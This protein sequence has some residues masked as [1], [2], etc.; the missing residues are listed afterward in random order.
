MSEVYETLACSHCAA[1]QRVYLGRTDDCTMPD[2][3]AFR[4]CSCGQWCALPD[5]DEH[6]ELIG[7][8]VPPAADLFGYPGEAL[9]PRQ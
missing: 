6:Y 4:C 3:E 7:D 1:A 8:P 5:L 2:V 9:E